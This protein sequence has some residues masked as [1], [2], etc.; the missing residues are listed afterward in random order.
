MSSRP[1]WQD[2]RPRRPMVGKPAGHVQATGISSQRATRH[3]QTHELKANLFGRL[4]AHRARIPV[5]IGT[6]WTLKDTAPSP[7]VVSR[8]DSPSG[9]RVARPALR[10]CDHD[11]GRDP[12]RMG[13]FVA[14]APLS[15]AVPTA[16]RGPFRD[17]NPLSGRI[18]RPE[19][20]RLG[21]VA[22]LSEEKGLST[23]LGA[24]PPTWRACRRRCCSSQAMAPCVRIWKV[25]RRSRSLVA[26]AFSRPRRRCARFSR[27]ARPVRNRRA[28]NRSVAVMEALASGLRS[29]PRA[30]AAFRRSSR[31]ARPGSLFRPTMFERSPTRSSPSGET[32]S[33]EGTRRRRSR[34]DASALPGGQLR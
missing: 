1:W 14:V 13:C 12:P 5:I 6:L 29:L 19:L 30:S 27:E 28:A 7:L 2:Y 21:V 8:P 22:R 16:R 23:M 31:T 26:R 34:D 15:N 18:E 17:R 3:L 25:W 33:A 4:A 9:R 20:F 10:L 32:S 24:M 11:L